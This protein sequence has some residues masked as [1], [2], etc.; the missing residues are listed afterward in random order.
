LIWT[1]E[2]LTLNTI[3]GIPFASH[4]AAYRQVSSMTH[5]PIGMIRPFCSATSM[6]LFADTKFPSSFF[7]FP[8][9]RV[10]GA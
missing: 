7:G 2:I 1:A 5:L 3:S 4:A 8:D 6:N 10:D 9:Y